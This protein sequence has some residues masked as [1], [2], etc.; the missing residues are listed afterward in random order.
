[1]DG[2]IYLLNQAG[3]ALSQANREIARLN[4]ELSKRDEPASE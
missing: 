1:M 2:I 4:A 3:I